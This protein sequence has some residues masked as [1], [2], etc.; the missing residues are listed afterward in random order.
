M[1]TL[2]FDITKISDEELSL[3]E[4]TLRHEATRIEKESREA[5]YDSNRKW[6]QAFQE[7]QKR[8]S[9]RE[10]LARKEKN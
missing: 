10:V 5:T 2:P 7:K 4:I 9:Y 8:E 1:I 6:Y 3:L